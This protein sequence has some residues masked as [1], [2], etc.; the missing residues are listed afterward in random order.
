M[1]ACACMYLSIRIDA[2]VS[3]NHM[4]IIYAYVC[5]YLPIRTNWHIASS[6]NKCK[7]SFSSRIQTLLQTA[8]CQWHR[9][10]TGRPT[11][12]SYPYITTA[13]EYSMHS[14]T[15]GLL[16]YEWRC[17][18]AED[19]EKEQILKRQTLLKR[20]V[21]SEGPE[22]SC[23]CA[24]KGILWPLEAKLALLTQP[25]ATSAKTNSCSLHW[26]VSAYSS[27]FLL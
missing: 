14:C 2:I 10:G 19:S 26:K 5:V 27:L 21:L 20:Q 25:P 4:Y 3:I 13:S 17:A 9:P 16:L 18:E 22:R 1:R 15:M 11:L 8:S 12:S 7:L 6:Q 23:E 24:R